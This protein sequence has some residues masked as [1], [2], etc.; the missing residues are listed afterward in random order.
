[1]KE[2]QDGSFSV[3]TSLLSDDICSKVHMCRAEQL[4]HTEK[5]GVFEGT[6]KYPRVV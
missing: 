3:R 4:I 6:K 2:W 1:M 5:L